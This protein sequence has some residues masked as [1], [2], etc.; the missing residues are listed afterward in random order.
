MPL[1]G[2][3]QEVA[4]ESRFRQA[5]IASLL[6]SCREQ[7][8]VAAPKGLMPFGNPQREK[9]FRCRS[10][11]FFA[12]TERALAFSFVECSVCPLQRIL[13]S[14][15][16]PIVKS[17]L[18]V[19]TLRWRLEVQ[20]PTRKTHASRKESAFS[21]CDAHLFA[22]ISNKTILQKSLPYLFAFS[23]KCKRKI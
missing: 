10:T 12:K 20:A 6:V 3:P 18:F 22:Q 11:H 23:F 14:K 9:S 4:E 5:E 1:L 17:N 13:Q 15:I 2:A 8:N 7:A 16:L 19:Q 21:A